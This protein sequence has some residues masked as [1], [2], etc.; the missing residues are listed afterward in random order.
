MTALTPNARVAQV[1]HELLDAGPIGHRVRP[2]AYRAFIDRNFEDSLA[3]PVYG[4]A[5]TNCAIFVRGCLVQAGILPRGK[6]PAIPAITTW[7]GVRGFA[8]DNPDTEA[9]EGAWIPVEELG[10]LGELIEPGDILFWTGYR[11]QKSIKEWGPTTNGHVG[12]V[13]FDGHS[14]IR[15]TYEGGGTAHR[16]Q[17]SAEPKDIR[18]SHQRPLRGV[19]RPAL[20]AQ[21][22]GVTL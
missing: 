11:W 18:E 10:E 17:R 13:G 21:R 20:I 6:R 22:L 8:E 19:W 14:W 4:S 3:A 16:C 5:G 7:I 15:T 2:E 9:I 1:A 12:L